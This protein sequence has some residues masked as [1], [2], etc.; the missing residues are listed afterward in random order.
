MEIIQYKTIP[1]GKKREITGYVKTWNLQ[2]TRSG[3]LVADL[4]YNGNKLR[5]FID[6]DVQKEIA[7]LVTYWNKA[8][9]RTD[10]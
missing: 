6:K 9:E 1:R 8:K 4:E 2:P 7:M 3:D 5:L 10:A